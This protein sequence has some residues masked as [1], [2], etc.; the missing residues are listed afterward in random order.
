M[1]VKV[2]AIRDAK[3]EAWLQPMFFVNTAQALRQF[4]DSLQDE[5]TFSKHPEDFSL[6]QLGEYDDTTGKLSPLDTP[7]CIGQAVEYKKAA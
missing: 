4:G 6:W 1:Q 2:Y 5:N 3:T 7:T